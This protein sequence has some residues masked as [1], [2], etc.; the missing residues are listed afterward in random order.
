[1]TDKWRQGLAYPY[2][3]PGEVSARPRQ[4]F[5]HILFFKVTTSPFGL[6]TAIDNGT[7]P[8]FVTE[9]YTPKPASIANATDFESSLGID[10]ACIVLPSV[11]GTNNSILV[12]ALRKFNGSYRG[13]A[14]IDPD[15][16]T[17]TTLAMFQE[18]GVRGCK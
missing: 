6:F 15:N 13:V 17:N 14:V 2:N 7:D 9:D 3:R 8:S 4:R 12:D 5:D 10:H 11:Y 16:I 1:M 18:A